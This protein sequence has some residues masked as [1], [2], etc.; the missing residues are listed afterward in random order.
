LGRVDVANSNGVQVSYRDRTLDRLPAARGDLCSKDRRA[1][2]PTGLPSQE[3]L[4]R[5]PSF[6]AEE[7]DASGLRK[8][9]GCDAGMEDLCYEQIAEI[10][11]ARI[12]TLAHLFR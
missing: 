4:N 9:A 8:L 11:G 7:I 5:P 12:G 3:L 1:P 6:N 10:T 2:F